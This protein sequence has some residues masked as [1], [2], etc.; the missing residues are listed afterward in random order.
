MGFWIGFLLGVF[1][2][3]CALTAGLWRFALHRE[4]LDVPNA[5][6][7]HDLPTPRGGGLAVV[8]TVLLALLPLWWHGALS[9][10]QGLGIGGAGIL[11]ALVGWLDDHGHVAAR[12][13]L[14]V[15][16][17]AAG[18][19]LYWLGGLPPVVLFGMAVDLGLADDLL[20]L[21]LL[22]WLLNLYNFM[23]GVDGIAGIEAFTVCLGAIGLFWVVAPN[24]YGWVLPATLALAVL[25]FLV[26]NY[27]PAKI[28]M[29]DAG[30]GFIGLLLGLL[31]MDAAHDNPRLLWGWVI[32]LA[33]F[34]AD[35]TVTLVRRLLK[36]DRVY[37]AHR[38]HAYQYLARQWGSHQR[39]SL[40]YG[41]I[42]I[43]WLLPIA[44]LTVTGRVDCLVGPAVAYVPLVVLAWCCKAG[45]RRAQGEV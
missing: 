10:S 26:W 8:I 1:V 23:D 11:V 39:V 15:H 44:L 13:R 25:G 21:V 24:T 19:G 16:F 28:F 40:L 20:A 33:A 45:D 31:L 9:P 27:P 30:S 43:V 3:S 18:W 42:N 12:W 14:L 38:S 37:E 35:A 29:G 2:L 41:A 32:L 22:V 34:V 4:W 5:R 7:S 36:G 17:L 6:S